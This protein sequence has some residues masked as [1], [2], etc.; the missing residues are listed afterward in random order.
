MDDYQQQQQEMVARAD[1]VQGPATQA[2]ERLLR[3]AE[4]SDSGQ[5]G[6]VVAFIAAT[7]NGAA[8]PLDLFIA[9]TVDVKIGDDMLMCIDALRWGRADLYKLVPDGERRIEAIIKDWGLQRAGQ[10]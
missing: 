2:Y 3:L 10:Q 1:R 5:A 6:K 8:Y 4:T 9:R 7:Y